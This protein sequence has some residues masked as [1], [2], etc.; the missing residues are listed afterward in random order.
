M[1][2]ER[3]W[4]G[5]RKWGR[6]VYHALRIVSINHTQFE[7]SKTAKQGEDTLKSTAKE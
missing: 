1:K 3:G 6:R 7:E 2:K 4:E 5:G